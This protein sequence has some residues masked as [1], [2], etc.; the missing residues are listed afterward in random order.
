MRG[1]I[2]L[3]LGVVVILGT[4]ARAQIFDESWQQATPGVYAPGST[5]NG[6]EGVWYV[7]DTITEVGTC[8]VSPQVAE[9]VAEDG[10]HV[11]E[12]RS[13]ESGSGCEDDIFV[14]LAEFD[15]QNVGFNIP[16]APDTILSFDEVGELTDPQWH[17]PPQDGVLPPCFD[18]VSL[19]LNDNNG[20]IL[21]YVLQR[22]LDAVA[23]VPNKNFGDTYR[24]I[25]LDPNAGS[26]RRNVFADFLTIPA[27]TPTGAQITYIEFRVDEHGSAT[28]DNLVIGSRAPA[29]TEAVLRFVSPV[30]GCQFYTASDPETLKLVDNYPD[31][32]TFEGVGFY[33]LPDANQ[34]GA[35]PVYRFWSPVLLSH[36]YTIS[37]REKDKLI[38]L[39][40][41]VWTFEGIAFFAFTAD[42]RPAET[43]PM[44]RLWNSQTGCHRYT[45]SETERD[46]LI[47]NFPD[48]WIYEEIA[49]YAYPP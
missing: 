5:I 38:D 34:T 30:F 16:L 28:L 3:L 32:W 22:R 44:Y 39:Y 11:L 40:P 2:S 23:N 4:A 36:F 17:N 20:N 8:G 10:N 15:S 46:E 43:A 24:E 42:L 14:A 6:D 33:A 1:R 9:I 26:Y 13:V 21:A 27:F 18:N 41:D 29:G 25:F 35:L 48:I 31:V 19:L 49:W 47:N 12:L 37:E 45:F 7:G